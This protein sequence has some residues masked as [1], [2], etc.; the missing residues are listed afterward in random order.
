MRVRVKGK[1]IVASLSWGDDDGM[2]FRMPTAELVFGTPDADGWRE[3]LAFLSVPEGV[4]HFKFAFGATRQKPGE[5]AQ[6]RDVAAYR[7]WP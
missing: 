1:G 4:N 6:F 7:L 3:G 5:K 2:C